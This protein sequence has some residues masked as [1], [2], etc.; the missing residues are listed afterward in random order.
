MSF[1]D[2]AVTAGY[3]I[4][5]EPQRGGSGRVYRATEMSTGQTVAIKVLS[6]GHD[7]ERLRREAELLERLDHD[8]VARLRGVTIIDDEPALIVDWIDGDP[9]AGRLRSDGALAFDA[10]MAAFGQLTH[11]LQAVHDAGIVHRD[12]SPAN[13]LM[14]PHG[15]VTLIDFGVSRSA[16]SATVTVDGT[17]AG[18]PRYL[19][20]EVISGADPT[21]LS[22]QYA[23]ALVLHE[24]L[25]GSWPFPEGDAIATALHHQLHSQPTP[26]DESDPTIPP[27]FSD[28]VLRALD[29]D[30]AQRFPSMT[31]F[32]TALENPTQVGSL[33]QGR[34][35]SVASLV[36]RIGLPLVL[37]AAIAAALLD[38]DTTDDPIEASAE[39]AT[40]T[41][42]P[43]TPESS[44]EP[45]ATV[46]PTTTD[47]V[48]RATVSTLAAG[49]AQQLACNLLSESAFETDRLPTNWFIDVD[50]PERAQVVV[51]ES[52]GIDGSGALQVGFPGNFGLFGE[53]V[54]VE[55]GTR[56]LF[57]ASA[58]LEGAV[59][60][61]TL[62]V[63][64]VDSEFVPIVGSAELDLVSIG[65]ADFAQLSLETEP[66]PPG[67]AWAVPRL[68]KDNSE[69]V[70]IVDELVFASGDSDCVGILLG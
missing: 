15:H 54:E 30:P 1:S 60:E 53:L 5:G 12:I 65:D 14:D 7:L 58:R 37:I 42:V 38:D 48:R 35:L 40:T 43:A 20:P 3:T 8:N 2:A 9:L 67:A 41:I 45:P 69:G 52:A 68:F 66:A 21:P 32:L 25:M 28:A 22:D 17:I 11:G 64:W 24:M 70:L 23:A 27:G 26:L 34:R 50:D 51:V 36:F 6:P 49:T 16:D 55:P 19:A 44:T 56:Y 39:A 63:D 18:T 33:Q 46:G 10:A 4:L 29:K 59:T 13:V 61:A 31:A 47:G 57:S 62:A